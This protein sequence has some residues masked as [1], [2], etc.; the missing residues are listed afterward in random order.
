[1]EIEFSKGRRGE[2]EITFFFI[3]LT[4]SFFIILFLLI[5]VM[6]ENNFAFER[7]MRTISERTTR[8]ASVANIKTDTGIKLGQPVLPIQIQTATPTQK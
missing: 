8:K 5:I 1:M 6:S 4:L 3:T 7:I 2:G